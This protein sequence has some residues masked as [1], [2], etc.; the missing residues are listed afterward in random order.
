MSILN[1]TYIVLL[2]TNGD[3][4]CF[5]I[6]FLFYY[7][8]LDKIKSNSDL[9]FTCY[10]CMYFHNLYSDQSILLNLIFLGSY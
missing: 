7:I 10:M 3:M 4:I 9:I 8:C 5:V 1:T 6:D 2:L